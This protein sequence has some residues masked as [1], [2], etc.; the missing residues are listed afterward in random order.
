M[1]DFADYVAHGWALC[2]IDRN[3]KRATYEGWNETPIPADAVEGLDGAG[4]LHVQSGTCCL[5]LDNLDAA[6]PWLAERGVDVDALLN[7]SDAVRIDSGRHGRAKLLYRM[8]RP[9]RTFKPKASGLELRCATAEG[10]SVQDVLPP[11]IHKDTQKPYR[12]LYPEPMLGHWSILPSIPASL[13]AVWRGLTADESEPVKEVETDKSKPV[14][15]LSKLKRAAFKHSPDCEYDEWIKVG[16]QLNDG[17]GGAQEGFNIWCEWSKGIK[18]KAYPGDALLKTHWLSFSSKGGKHVATGAAL[19]NELPADA[20][21]FPIE[22]PN[23]VLEEET[24]KQVMELNKREALAQ[25]SC[26]LEERLVFVRGVERYF[27]TEQQ[28]IIGSDNTIEHIFTPLMPRVKGGR[29]NPVKVLKASTTKRF[30]DSIGFHPGEGVLFDSNGDSFANTY[31]GKLAEPVKPTAMELEKIHWLFDRIDDAHYRDWLLQY[32]GHVVQHPGVKIKSAPL[33]WSETQGNGKTT[34][35]KTIPMHLVGIPYSKEVTFSLL[36]SDFNDYLLNAWHVNLTE[37]RAGTRGER[38]AISKKIENWIADDTISIHPKGMAGYTMPNHLF[39]TATSNK[40]DAAAIDNNDRKWAIHEMHAPQFTPKQQDW[41]YTDFLL[42]PRAP[43][44]LRH[45]FLN[46]SLKGFNPS[47]R[48][49]ETAAR[50]AM[51][52]SSLSPDH[53][54]LLTAFEQRAMPLSC[55]IVVTQEVGDYV[56]KHC[57]SKP[58]NDRIGRTLCRYP[59]NGVPHQWRSGESRYRAIA[60]VKEVVDLSL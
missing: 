5:D 55:D 29:V 19:A 43:G 53:E 33:I 21:E 59:F 18:R 24:T 10:K 50:Q 34:L 41:I 46:L 48:A 14:I 22:E 35:L 28:R 6:R 3:S 20:D 8:K 31:R 51:T 38:E 16:M 1:S 26:K 7:A 39:I 40:D 42:T 23:A 60:F 54:L 52:Q 36:N 47:A 49:L 56:R 58:S 30:V 57:I 44:V 17:T 15:D 25:A 37:F 4:L 12:W 2:S 27:D 13:L 32:F 45:Y 9:L 11:T